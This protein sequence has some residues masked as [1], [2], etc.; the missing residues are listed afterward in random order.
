MRRG[1]AD[2]TRSHHK[3]PVNRIWGVPG[4]IIQ[5]RLWKMVAVAFGIGRRYDRCTQLSLRLREP[6]ASRLQGHCLWPKKK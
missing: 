1:A 5:G 2:E 3:H 4:K 6:A